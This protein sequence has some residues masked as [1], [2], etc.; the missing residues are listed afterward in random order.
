MRLTLDQ[1]MLIYQRVTDRSACAGEGAAWWTEV[2][3]ELEAVIA[4]LTAAT[5]ADVIA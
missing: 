4:A 2:Q 1:A 5:G 3:A